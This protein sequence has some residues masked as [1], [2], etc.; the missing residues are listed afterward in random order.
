MY[1]ERSDNGVDAGE[2]SIADRRLSGWSR[3]GRS[4]TES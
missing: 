4:R 3:A 1:T 2:R